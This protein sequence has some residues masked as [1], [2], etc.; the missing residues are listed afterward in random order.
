MSIA[1]LHLHGTPRTGT[2]TDTGAQQR[3]PGA[4]EEQAGESVFDGYKAVVWD[5]EKVWEQ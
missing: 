1:R 3:C 5:D 2:L 4:G